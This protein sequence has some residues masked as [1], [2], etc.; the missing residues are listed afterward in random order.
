VLKRSVRLGQP[1]G[2]GLTTPVFETRRHFAGIA[3]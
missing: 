3:R 1:S 2:R